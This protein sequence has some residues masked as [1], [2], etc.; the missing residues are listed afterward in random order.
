MVRRLTPESPP[1]LLC[2]RRAGGLANQFHHSDPVGP[3]KLSPAGVN[4]DD[5]VSTYALYRHTRHRI[6]HVAA[7][8]ALPEVSRHAEQFSRQILVSW[9]RHEIGLQLRLAKPVGRRCAES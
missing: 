1:G 6:D 4:V 2:R 8:A 9:I 7:F 3:A 5:D